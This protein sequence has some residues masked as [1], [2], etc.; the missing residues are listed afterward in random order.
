M[1]PYVFAE[2]GPPR[3]SEYPV[4][5]AIP[6]EKLRQD[7]GAASWDAE[8]VQETLISKTRV[9]IHFDMVRY[10][11]WSLLGPIEH[12]TEP[13]NRTVKVVSGYDETRKHSVE[14]ALN[15]AGS[16]DIPFGGLKVEVK[17]ELK[18]TDDITQR[19]HKETTTTSVVNFRAGYTYA[20]WALR[21]A[22]SVTKRT[23]YKVFV[24]FNPDKLLSESAP[25]TEQRSADSVIYV[26]NDKLKDKD[27]AAFRQSFAGMP[28]QEV[29]QVSEEP[30]SSK[31]KQPEIIWWAS[32]DTFHPHWIGP[33]RDNQ[34]DASEDARE[35]DEDVHSGEER[36][37]VLSSDDP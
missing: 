26:F 24:G 2:N 16:A 8:V 30:L 15:I 19:W 1:Q 34:D 5:T 12:F 36:A 14:K 33:D 6:P 29:G 21:D 10:Q 18:I 4:P 9:Y 22:V 27:Q 28:F 23:W 25:I 32:C 35:H 11:Y 31:P 13:E 37:V 7:I 20:T 3:L 17:A